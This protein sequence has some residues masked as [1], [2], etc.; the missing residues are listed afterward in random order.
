MG[1]LHGSMVKR[2]LA[3]GSVILGLAF[4]GCAQV[5]A[6][7]ILESVEHEADLRAASACVTQYENVEQLR[8]QAAFIIRTNA[9]TLIALAVEP[10]PEAQQRIAQ[11]RKLV[12][13]DVLEAQHIVDIVNPC[14]R[15]EAKALLETE[16]DN[17]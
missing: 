12:E 17:S 5:R 7:Q 3:I 10:D 15:A 4:L 9:E 8:A 1:Q 2:W 14:D 6:Q 16:K 13:A 11:F